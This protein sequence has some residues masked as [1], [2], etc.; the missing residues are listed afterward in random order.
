MSWLA[1]RLSGYTG[2]GLSASLSVIGHIAMV[3]VACLG[4]LA[5]EIKDHDENDGD[6]EKAGGG[7]T[8]L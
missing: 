3:S 2:W 8:E 7:C 4:E 1:T 6:G 5:T